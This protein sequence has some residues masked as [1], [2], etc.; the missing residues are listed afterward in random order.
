MT[1]AAPRGPRTAQITRTDCFYYGVVDTL[2][3]TVALI[4]TACSVRRPHP[5][6]SPVT[7]SVT[8]M[9]QLVILPTNEQV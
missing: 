5:S 1:W 7:V 8:V 9:L 4:G 2:T 3:T 6:R